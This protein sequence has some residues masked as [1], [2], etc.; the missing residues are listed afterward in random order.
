MRKGNI[1]TAVPQSLPEEIFETLIDSGAVRIERII[2]DSNCSP[3]GFWYD[4]EESEWVMVLEGS[5]G[6]RFE[7]DEQIL[8][9]R[10][11]D[12]VDIPAHLKHRV[13]WTEPGRKTVWLAVFY[14]A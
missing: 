5:A 7:G 3:E 9:L 2:S 13:E 8:V 1:Y 10:P 14:G 4:Q 6:L 11:G 12:W